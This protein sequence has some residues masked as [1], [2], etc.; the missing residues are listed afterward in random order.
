[1]KSKTQ[2]QAK[3]NKLIESAMVSALLNLS[4]EEF[5]SLSWFNY[6]GE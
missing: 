4:K 1:M 5:Q 2:Q 3:M 6:E